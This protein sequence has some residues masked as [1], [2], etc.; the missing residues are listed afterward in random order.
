MKHSADERKNK[1]VVFAMIPILLL[2][3]SSFA[4]GGKV[5]QSNNACN[6]DILQTFSLSGLDI[7]VIEQLE[8]CPSITRSC[9]LKQDQQIMY[10]NF[11]HGGEFQSVV[12]HYAKVVGVYN[13]LIE[14]LVDVQEFAK[15][16]KDNIQKKVSNCKLLAERILNYEVSQVADQVRQN[17]QKLSE[18]FEKTYSGFYCTICNFDNHKYFDATT[19]T[20]F[21]SEKFCRDIVENTLPSLLMFHVDI[22]KHLNLVTKFVTSCDFIGIYNLDAVFPANYTFSVVM[23][24]V[25]DLQSC[26]DNRNKREWFS[27]C[28]DICTNFKLTGYSEYFQP[29][30][31]L[32][33]S[34]TTFL[35]Q[36]LN[37]LTAAKDSR[38]L[39]GALS[40]PTGNSG[41]RILS[42]DDHKPREIF[43]PGISA[44]VDFSKWNA[45]F[46]M[47][48]IS[49]M[50]EGINSLINEQTYSVVKTFLQIM[51]AGNKAPQVNVPVTLSPTASTGAHSR[52][53]KSSFMMNV[54][55]SISLLMINLLK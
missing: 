16:V 39:F 23:D 53:L 55:V 1:S 20:I 37:A 4:D 13:G 17:L 3:S 2:I 50:D 35:S 8:M 9:C 54:G 30:F 48:G 14:K 26:R 10:T 19:Q 11:I 12:D 15:T 44:K 18:F 7:P 6:R 22:I 31:K 49:Y 38:P 24:V 34:Y 43:T 36:T 29:N 45:D 28:K 5:Q 42:E 25:Q 41:K 52:K 51:A 21:Y 33:A 40:T 47:Q 46:L 32:M 27:Y